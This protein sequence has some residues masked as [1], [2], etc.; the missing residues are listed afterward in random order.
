[1]KRTMNNPP[2]VEASIQCIQN[3]VPTLKSS[4]VIGYSY[5]D[6]GIDFKSG[7]IDISIWDEL[8]KLKYDDEKVT[9]ASTR[10]CYIDDEDYA[11]VFTGASGED[12]NWAY[13]KREGVKRAPLAF[14][15]RLVLYYE[16]MKLMKAEAESENE[17]VE[18]ETKSEQIDGIELLRRV[19]DKAAKIIKSGNIEKIIKFL[20]D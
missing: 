18:I 6:M 2:E 17:V 14:V 4:E 3:Y 19:N 20:E 7:I 16:R 5:K 15:T 1:M 12:N 13:M 10:G 9:G 11:L 8:M